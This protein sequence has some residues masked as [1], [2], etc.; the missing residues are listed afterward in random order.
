MVLADI[1]E[2]EVLY[3]EDGQYAANVEKAVSLAADAVVSPFNQP[4]IRETPGTE[5]IEK[6]AKFLD[7][8]ASAIVK[9][10]LY[11]VIYDSE[12]QVIVMVSIRADQEVNE[13]KLIK[14]FPIAI[15][16]ICIFAIMLLI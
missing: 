13:V 6:L 8:S 15:V 7:C 11:E 1:G 5:T 3:T 12:I 2:D 9:N 14:S 4:E 16:V 10:V